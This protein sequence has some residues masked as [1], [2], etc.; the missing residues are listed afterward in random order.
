V[1]MKCIPAFSPTQRN[2]QTTMKSFV[3]QRRPRQNG[4][5]D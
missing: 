2:V 1:D 4:V 5:P 3:D